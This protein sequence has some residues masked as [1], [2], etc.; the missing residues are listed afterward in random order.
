MQEQR[1]I[2]VFVGSPGDVFEERKRAFEVIESINRDQ[3][4]PP[5]WRFEGVAWDQTHYPKHARLSPQEAI[6]QGILQPGDCDIALF[7]FWKRVGTPLPPGT[8]TENGAGAEPTGSLWEFHNALASA[9]KPWVL[10]YRCK[11]TPEMSEKD[12]EDPVGFG[13]QVKGVKDFFSGFKDGEGHYRADYYGYTDTD[14]FAHHLEQDLKSFIKQQTSSEVNADYTVKPK[15]AQTERVPAAYLQR[16][17]ESVAHVELLGLNLKESITNGLPQVYVPAVTTKATDQKEAEEPFG[18]ERRELILHRLDESSLYLPGDPGSGKSTF[19][20]WVAYVVADGAVTAHEI[21]AAEE[22]QERLPDSLVGRL[23]LLIRLR[24]FWGLM[25]CVP[26]QGDW[27]QGELE[28]AIS[29]WLD[30]KLP[31][32]LTASSFER[33]LAEGNLLLLL[34]GVDEVPEEQRVEAKTAYPRH[35]LLTGLV[36]ALPQWQQQGNRILITSRPYG[37]RAVERDRL[38]LPEVA[39]LPLDEDLQRLFMARW[40]GAAGHAHWQAYSDDLAE[41]LGNRPELNELQRNP[42]LLTALCVKYKEGK[43]LPQDIYHLYD[44]VVNQVLFNRFRSSDRERTRVRWRL[45]AVALGMHYGIDDQSVRSAPL[46]SIDLDELDRILACYA[47]LNPGTEGD[48]ARVLERRDELL[49]RSGLLL[50]RGAGKAEFYHQDFRDYLAAER[51]ARERRTFVSALDG[52]GAK[53]DWRRML[54]F[55]FAKEI[56]SSGGIDQPLRA[57]AELKAKISRDAL[58]TEAA[59]A[60]LLAD[61]LEIAEGKA[62]ES[63][64]SGN[65]EAFFRQVC[66]DSLEV[67]PAALDR[68]TLFLALGRLGWDNRA[69]LGLDQ[70]DRPDIRWLAV[71]DPANPAFYIAQ[72]PVTQAQFQAFIEAEDG[73]ANPRWWTDFEA[74]KDEPSKPTWPEPNAPRTDVDWF[75]AVAFCRWLTHLGITPTA[76]WEILLPTYEQW[77]HAYVGEGDKDFPWEREPD[78]D[79]H[80]NFWETGL[81]R[82]SAV[83]LFPAGVANSGALDMGGN[84]DEWCLQKYDLKT[85]EVGSAALDATDDPRVLRGGSWVGNPDDLRSAGR[86]R[87]NPGDRYNDVGFRLVCRPPSAVEH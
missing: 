59:A 28:A 82:T 86:G 24:D 66:A 87:F 36:D 80:A 85:Y 10:V 11:R 43:R 54:G 72:Y 1:V 39:L 30:K 40:Y 77:R 12:F 70:Q 46:A 9:K 22:L 44:S 56:E 50:P 2:Q 57:L 29:H 26:E 53:R 62:G 37:L 16:L 45:E 25:G 47:K 64:L 65:W 84:V 76:G 6:N 68:N 81:Y 33:N 41:E 52:Y 8:F 63:G 71:P 21:S 7:I 15:A 61:C 79:R 3:L 78:A 34:D 60:L 69:G 75:E 18:R 42:L 14:D 13:Q 83:G 17:K 38:R 32:G 67:V 4:L 48:D 49:E 58:A 20:Q 19:S 23:P 74:R 73:Y 35:A 27:S 55:L 5:G 51:W 31:F